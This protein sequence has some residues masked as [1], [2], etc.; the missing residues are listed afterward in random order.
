MCWFFGIF[1]CLFYNLHVF[2][3]WYQRCWQFHFICSNSV[4]ADWQMEKLISIKQLHFNFMNSMQPN[5][6]FYC[7]TR[8]LCTSSLQQYYNANHQN[9]WII[10]ECQPLWQLCKQSGVNLFYINRSA[11][12]AKNNR[13]RSLRCS[14]LFFP[15][16][17][18][19]LSFDFLVLFVSTIIIHWIYDMKLMLKSI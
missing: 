12:N 18:L 8:T 3:I 15:L 13:I 2:N 7:A 10:V 1:F 4:E 16:V 5:C 19:S 11:I 6:I 9:I 17:F 14:T